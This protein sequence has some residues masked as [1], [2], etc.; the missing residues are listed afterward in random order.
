MT[1]SLSWNP[2]T[3][4][5]LKIYIVKVFVVYRSSHRRSSIKKGVL[6]NFAKF[7]GK[8]PC[9]SSFFNKVVGWDTEHRSFP[10]NCRKFLK[11]PFYRTAASL[12]IYLY[13]FFFP[14]GKL[15]PFSK[16]H[17]YFW[18]SSI[19]LLRRHITY[20]SSKSDFGIDIC[21]LIVL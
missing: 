14:I 8:H 21:T 17:P 3:F 12:F 7:T 19:P 9:Q 18:E 11:I 13:L 2:Q 1:F 5:S 15:L 16:D 4:T 6:K 20:N 10:V